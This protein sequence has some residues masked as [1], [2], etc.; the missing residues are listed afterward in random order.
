MRGQHFGFLGVLCLA[1]VTARVGFLSLLP[2]DGPDQEFPIKSL[3]PDTQHVE[4]GKAKKLASQRHY[5]TVT[6][7]YRS[8][9]A[10]VRNPLASERSIDSIAA[11]QSSPSPNNRLA[12]P[13]S[14][15]PATI[16]LSQPQKKFQQRSS[17]LNIYVYSFIRQGSYGSRLAGTGQYGG[18]Q[19][20]F[21]A[22]HRLDGE[23]NRDG[24][25]GISI[26]A[27]GAVAHDRLTEREL[28]AGLRW[29]P[30]SDL[31]VVLTAER[32]FRN[33][34][35]D[36]FAFYLAGGKSDIALPLK[37][38]LDAFAQGGFVSGQD[39]GPFF[40][41]S[42]RAERRLISIGKVPIDIG[43]G[44]WG[45]GQK[46]IFRV[47]AGPTI[48]T[49]MPIGNN[50]LHINADWRFRIAGDAAPANGPALTLSTSF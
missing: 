26:L 30:H 9:A 1:W 14:I 29:Q 5:R 38:R 3:H 2:V 43:A 16:F 24:Q 4:K 15:V 8:S 44:S 45:G 10:S 6:V 48:G 11:T 49:V 32:R 35:P 12:E 7:Q 31:P 42:T 46:G 50:R 17:R 41:V 27:R 40:D 34:R 22:T 25:A 20:G 36:A 33:A 28:A 23:V 47:D 37:F 19:S 18:S 39:G 13:L 21:V